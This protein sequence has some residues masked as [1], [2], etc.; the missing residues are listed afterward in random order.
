MRKHFKKNKQFYIGVGTGICVAGF[1]CLI[2]REPRAVLRGG[3]DC[4]IQEPTGSLFSS[5]R[6]IFG[7]ASSTVTTIHHGSKGHP[8][9]ITKCLETGE[10]F[11]TQGA[12]ARA[13]GIPEPVL[14]GHLN[15]GLSLSE[16][17]HFERVGILA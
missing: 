12:A 3:T 8:G 6:S 13:F 15:K 7:P 17:L 5:A 4:P 10:I 14:S 2:M 11:A 16:D 1:T 9:F